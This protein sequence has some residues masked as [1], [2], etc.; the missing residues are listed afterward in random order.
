M[1]TLDDEFLI[2]SICDDIDK[3]MRLQ[4]SRLLEDRFKLINRKQPLGDFK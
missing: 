1:L 4:Y 2:F 3:Q